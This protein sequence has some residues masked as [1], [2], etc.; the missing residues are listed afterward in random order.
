MPG[1]R[2]ANAELMDPTRPN[3]F[4]GPYIDRR[5]D[6]RE[7]AGWPASALSDPETLYILARDTTQ[8]VYTGSQPRIAFVTREHPALYNPAPNSLTLL[9]CYQGSRCVLAELAEG[10]EVEL[11]AGTSFEELRPLPPLLP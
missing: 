1:I 2:P 7:E 10:E 4:A 6:V 9:G 8:L 11:P 3:F 5:A